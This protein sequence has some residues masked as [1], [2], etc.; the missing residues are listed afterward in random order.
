MPTEMLLMHFNFSSTSVNQYMKPI[1]EAQVFLFVIWIGSPSQMLHNC[2]G[3][4]ARSVSIC[5][6]HIACNYLFFWFTAKKTLYLPIGSKANRGF[7]NKLCSTPLDWKASIFLPCLTGSPCPVLSQRVD[8][9][10]L[11]ACSSDNDGTDAVFIWF[12]P[13]FALILWVHTWSNAAGSSF[14]IV[15]STGPATGC[16]C[17]ACW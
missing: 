5:T 9:A 17:Q 12:S 2:I 7:G 8:E 4:E 10:K 13:T 16:F 3:I 15:F 14:V 11:I 6:E 1:K